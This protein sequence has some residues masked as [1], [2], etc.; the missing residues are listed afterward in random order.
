[1]KQNVDNLE[2]LNDKVS[3]FQPAYDPS[4]TRLSIQ[5]Q[6]EVAAKG[7]QALS[8]VEDAERICN[9]LISKRALAFELLNPL[10]TRVIN[11]LRI[12]D[13]LD[14][15]L[16]EGESLVRELRNQR[17]SEIEPPSE[18]ADGTE[19]EK[20]PRTN[21]KRSG[22]FETKIENFGKLIKLL[23]SVVTYKP[24]ETDLTVESLKTRLET[25][26]QVNSAAKAATANAEAARGLRDIVLFADKTGLYDIAM[27][28]K[29]YV[30][31]AY[32]AT[33]TQYKLI[34]GISFSKRR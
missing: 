17:A 10:V 26:I 5:N 11:G 27:D 12:V 6:K 29:L 31:S 25:L 34:S 13:I 8:G 9:D 14:H 4:E 2:F 1:M 28:S 18:N 20:L 3:T 23:G 24:N 22:S 21:K 16:A 15:T 32:G 7:K 33:S 19:N 30:K